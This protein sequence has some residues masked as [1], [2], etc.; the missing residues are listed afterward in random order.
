MLLTCIAFDNWLFKHCEELCTI[1]IVPFSAASL[2]PTPNAAFP[3]Q[4]GVK[5]GRGNHQV[6]RHVY[7]QQYT[8]DNLPQVTA[9]ALFRVVCSNFSKQK[10]STFLIIMFN[11]GS[12]K[13]LWIEPQLLP[14]FKV[15]AKRQPRHHDWCGLL[16]FGP[17]KWAI[18][19]LSSA[20]RYKTS[21]F[22]APVNDEVRNSMVNYWFTMQGNEPAS[23]P[24]RPLH[25]YS[26]SGFCP[27]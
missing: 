23:H 3:R 16:G 27:S 25:A 21:V 20:N 1:F 9:L 7:A 24:W 15:C 14:R 19:N 12:G 26:Q 22:P 18:I 13:S 4:L 11:L 2:T 10:G 8:H 6:L 5:T 17:K